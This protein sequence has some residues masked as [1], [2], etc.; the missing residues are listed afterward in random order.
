MASRD[1]ECIREIVR[2][3]VAGTGA[4]VYLFGSQARGDARAGSDVDLAI[5]HADCL[6][7]GALARLREAFEEAAILVRVDVVDLAEASPAI[8][9]SVSREGLRWNP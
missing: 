7:P 6:P 4:E 5:G 1:L 2:Q 3:A 9:A 8:R